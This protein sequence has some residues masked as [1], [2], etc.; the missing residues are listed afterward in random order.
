[1]RSSAIRRRLN[2]DGGLKPSIDS[3]L[4]Q[5]PLP[6]EAVDS[7]AELSSDFAFK[8]RNCLLHI[9]ASVLIMENNIAKRKEK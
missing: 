6:V 2:S 5:Y 8:Y 3:S 7:P 4:I 1:M 9:E